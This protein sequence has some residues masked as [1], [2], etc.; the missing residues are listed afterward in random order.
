MCS[1]LFERT[2][3]TLLHPSLD[4][5]LTFDTSVR[6]AEERRDSSTAEPPRTHAPPQTLASAILCLTV[7]RSLLCASCQ[8]HLR[9]GHLRAAHERGRVQRAHQ[10]DQQARGVFR[11]LPGSDFVHCD[12]SG[13]RRHGDLLPAGEI[14]YLLCCTGGTRSSR[15]IVFVLARGGYF[16][17]R[18]S[19][20]AT[21]M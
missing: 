14:S 8:I 5:C 9:R 2:S 1:Y 16:G 11:G 13:F 6:S 19:L 17:R 7:S 3:I 4:M 15:L 12:R 18:S 21:L 20:R 10:H